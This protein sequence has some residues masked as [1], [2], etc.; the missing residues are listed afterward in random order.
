MRK[1]IVVIFVV[2]AFEV[3]S[4]YLYINIKLDL[5]KDTVEDYLVTEKGVAK[6]DIKVSKPVYDWIKAKGDKKWF[7]C[8]EIMGDQGTY[9][10]YKDHQK[11]KVKLDYYILHGVEYSA[12]EYE[13]IKGKTP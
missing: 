13:K 5:T 3:I 1:K 4:S 2:I 11:N 12:R 9:Y 10:Y 6:K 8:V 7:V